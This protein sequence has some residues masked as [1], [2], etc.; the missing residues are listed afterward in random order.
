MFPQ[1][2]GR[3]EWMGAEGLSPVGLVFRKEQKGCFSDIYIQAMGQGTAFLEERKLIVLVKSH[4]FYLLSFTSGRGPS[5]ERAN[6]LP[7]K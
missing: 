3:P 6:R 7:R 1:G 4:S 2:A 5:P